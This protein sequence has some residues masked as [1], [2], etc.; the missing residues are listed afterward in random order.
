[1]QDFDHRRFD[2]RD[3]VGVGIIVGASAFDR[4]AHLDI[5]RLTIEQ[6]WGVVA[7]DEFGH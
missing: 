1:L 6:R 5:K 3:Q 7:M 4:I 2:G